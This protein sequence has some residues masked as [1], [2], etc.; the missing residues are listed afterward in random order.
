MHHMIGTEQPDDF[1][2][3]KARIISSR[4]GQEWKIQAEYQNV[5]RKEWGKKDQSHGGI[6]SITKCVQRQEV[7]TKAATKWQLYR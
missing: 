4:Q 6:T 7:Y 1:T 2:D 3:V 5:Y